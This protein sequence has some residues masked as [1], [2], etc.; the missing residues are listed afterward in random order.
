MMPWRS[1]EDDEAKNV[2]L[3]TIEVRKSQHILCRQ[4]LHVQ[5]LLLAKC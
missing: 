5:L 4:F 3:I 1:S 2:L